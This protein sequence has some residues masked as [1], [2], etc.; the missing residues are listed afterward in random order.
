MAEVAG[1]IARAGEAGCKMSAIRAGVEQVTGVSLSGADATRA[2]KD[3]LQ[4]GRVH[5][6]GYRYVAS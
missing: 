4:E 5:R 1:V 6:D 3:L 2:V